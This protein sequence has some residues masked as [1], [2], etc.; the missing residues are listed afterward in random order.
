MPLFLLISI[1]KN[2]PKFSHASFFCHRS[3]FHNIMALSLFLGS[4]SSYLVVFFLLYVMV[5]VASSFVVQ[6]K[7]IYFSFSI[8]KR[9]FS[10]EMNNWYLT[11]LLFS[12]V[13]DSII[14]LWIIF[15]FFSYL[16]KYWLGQLT[17]FFLLFCYNVNIKDFFINWLWCNVRLVIIIKRFIFIFSQLS[18]TLSI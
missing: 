18:F 1:D 12:H 8:F 10:Y 15:V 11:F 13:C 14:F 2:L 5:V 9:F 7:K 6:S 16:K 3:A 4:C 17:M